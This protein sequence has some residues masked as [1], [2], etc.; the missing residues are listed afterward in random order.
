MKLC[1]G[2]GGRMFPPP[3]GPSAELPIGP[4]RGVLGVA[5]ACGTKRCSGCG[6]RMWYP[7]GA[8]R[9]APYGAT[10]R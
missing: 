5:G 2:R 7:P 8:L 6:R 10:K 9:G 4:R 1:T 3:L